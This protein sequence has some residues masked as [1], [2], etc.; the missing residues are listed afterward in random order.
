MAVH[1][2]KE[3]SRHKGHKIVCVGY[4]MTN[5]AIECEDCGEVLIDFER[6]D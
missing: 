3:L 5:V 1:N 4:A 2:Y 6:E